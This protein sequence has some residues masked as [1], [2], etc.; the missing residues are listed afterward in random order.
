MTS[1]DDHRRQRSGHRH[2]LRRPLRRPSE[3]PGRSDQD[4]RRKR[5]DRRAGPKHL[6]PSRAPTPTTCDNLDRG[7][8]TLRDLGSADPEWPT[9]SSTSSTTTP[10]TPPT[11]LSTSVRRRRSMRLRRSSARS[12]SPGCG[13]PNVWANSSTSARWW[14]ELSGSVLGTHRPGEGRSAAS[15]RPAHFVD[16]GAKL[17]GHVLD[18]LVASTGDDPLS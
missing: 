4:P 16:R 10:T 9:S 8:A 3:Q 15:G 1:G 11:A 14:P 18:E 17:A 12:S 13:E 7:F 6:S 5:K 2:R